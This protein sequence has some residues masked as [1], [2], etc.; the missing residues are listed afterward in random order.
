MRF[1]GDEKQGVTPTFDTGDVASLG[2]VGE[3]ILAL[4]RGGEVADSDT[5]G[6]DA[7][8]VGVE[9]LFLD[10]LV[11]AL[12]LF[13]LSSLD[14]TPGWSFSSCSTR[15]LLG[16]KIR[17]GLTEGSKAV[18]TAAFRCC[19]MSMRGA[20]MIVLLV[21]AGFN[22]MSLGAQIPGRLAGF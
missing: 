20:V 22:F 12:S 10:G 5:G 19:S 13:S 18:G 7:S 21:D 9:L 16:A 11:N 8:C 2:A 6:V 17:A 1:S 3:G 14:R 4:W 15:F